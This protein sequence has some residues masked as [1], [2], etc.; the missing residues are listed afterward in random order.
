MNFLLENYH[1][2][3]YFA[4]SRDGE[5]WYDS[6]YE[7]KKDLINF[8]PYGEDSLSEE[9]RVVVYDLKDAPIDEYGN[10]DVSDLTDYIFE[11]YDNKLYYR[12]GKIVDYVVPK[13]KEFKTYKLLGSDNKYYNVK[14][15]TKL[16]A[17]KKLKKY[18]DNLK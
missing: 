1:K 15:F 17:I 2:Y 13:E 4:V 6:L 3:K 18:L 11:F 5:G 14:A 7:V 9:D 12:N 16:E 10:Q 8:I